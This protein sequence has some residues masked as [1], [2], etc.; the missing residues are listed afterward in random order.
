VCVR[1]CVCCVSER[2]ANCIHA[3]PFD[4]CSLYAPGVCV[5]VCVCVCCVC[6][7]SV[8]SLSLSLSLYVCVCDLCVCLWFVGQVWMLTGDKEETAVNIGV[9]CN[10]LDQTKCVTHP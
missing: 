9:A 8:L 3:H 10:L 7:Y 2:G 5:C 6:V 1:V 4:P